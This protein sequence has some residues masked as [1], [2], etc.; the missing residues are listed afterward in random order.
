[1][2][3][4]YAEALKRWEWKEFREG[5]I[6][7][8]IHKWGDLVCDDC[9]S[10]TLEGTLRVHHKVYYKGRLP[11]EYSFDDLRLVCKNCHETIHEAENACR[12][13][14][15]TLPP[16]VC[17]EFTD[18]LIELARLQNPRSVK[19]ALARAKNFAKELT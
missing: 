6:A 2:I 14:I 17:N 4:N 12:W 11:W 7:S 10:D 3:L 5:F 1:M 13:L 15:R 16:H 18:F 9:G 19:T 8:R